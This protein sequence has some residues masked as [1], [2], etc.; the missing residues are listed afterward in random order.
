MLCV[1]K[2]TP[3]PLEAANKRRNPSMSHAKC[4]SVVH[5]SSCTLNCGQSELQSRARHRRLLLGSRLPTYKIPNSEFHETTK[6]TPRKGVP[7]NGRLSQAIREIRTRRDDSISSS[8]TCSVV[9]PANRPSIRDGDR[10]RF[11]RQS[12]IWRDERSIWRE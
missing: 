8:V 4:L 11:R 2:S 6:T 5:A 10:T 3:E 7:R 1:V 12:R 9:S